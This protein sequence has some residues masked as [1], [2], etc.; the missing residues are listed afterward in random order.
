MS[1]DF[2]VWKRGSVNETVKNVYKQ[3]RK[4]LFK[5]INVFKR[6]N[7]FNSI[8]PIFLR[9][10]NILKRFYMCLCFTWK[11]KKRKSFLNVY[12]RLQ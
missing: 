3:N 6:F 2:V 8:L 12:K 9:I 11:L 7:M 5:S 4:C 10:T 1:C